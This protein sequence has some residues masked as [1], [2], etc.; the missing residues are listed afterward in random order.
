MTYW[1][2]S[3]KTSR[4]A[5]IME[6]Q[7]TDRQKWTTDSFIKDRRFLPS[8][9]KKDFRRGDFCILNV[10]GMKQLVAD[11]TIASEEQKDSAGDI[12]YDI[13]AVNEWDYPVAQ[14]LLPPKYKKLIVRSPS[15]R[16]SEADYHELVGIRT[17]VGN[18]RFNYKNQLSVHIK[19]TDVEKMMVSNAS[20]KGLQLQII[21]EQYELAPGNRID[22]LCRDQRG[23]L[24][25]VVAAPP[26]DSPTDAG[27]RG[28]P[29]RAPAGC[30]SSAANDGPPR[31]ECRCRR[32]LPAR[33]PRGV[34]LGRGDGPGAQPALGQ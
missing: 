2:V 11:F 24:V 15:K 17:F 6:W 16:I 7:D 29:G 34:L 9:C 27:P 10:Y 19:E 18:L 33:S 28:E 20:L 22:F 32:D 21:E 3:S 23:D 30:G 1:I 8:N 31:R 5:S 14:D 26:H 25:V 13:G 4:D 12:F